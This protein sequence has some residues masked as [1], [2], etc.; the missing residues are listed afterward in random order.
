MD[1]SNLAAFD[2]GRVLPN[3][4]EK[5]VRTGVQV[6]QSDGAVIT[7]KPSDDSQITVKGLSTEVPVLNYVEVN[8]IAENSNTIR[9]VLFSDFG[10]T[11]GANSY[12]QSCQLA[13]GEFISL[14]L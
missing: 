10:A 14:F 9:A 8:G 5:K 2:N 6:T 3:F 4:I 12:D 7:R 1:T 13:N 11:F